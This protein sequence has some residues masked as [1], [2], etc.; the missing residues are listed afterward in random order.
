MASYIQGVTD[1]IPEIQPFKPDLNFYTKVLQ[2]KQNQYDSALKSINNLYGSLLYSPLTGQDNI[3]RRDDYFKMIEQ[4][5]KKVTS[6][7]LSLP[8]NQTIAQNIFKPLLDDK[9]LMKDYTFTKNTLNEINYG[10]SFL[11]C[12]KPEDCPGGYW[13][14]GMNYLYMQLDDFAKASPEKR[15]GMAS[16]KYVPSYNMAAEIYKFASD[17]KLIVSQA[18]PSGGYIIKKQNGKEMEPYLKDTFMAVFG[19]DPRFQAMSG[20]RAAIMRKSAIEANK[21]KFGGDE[22]KAEDDWFN[23]VITTTGTK[24][25]EIAKANDEMLKRLGNKKGAYE[26]MIRKRGVVKDAGTNDPLLKE[27]LGTVQDQ[28]VAT[29]SN[30]YYSSLKE[31]MASI[32]KNPENRDLLRSK[33]DDITAAGLLEEEIGKITHDYAMENNAIT[34]ISADPFVIEAQ[35]HSNSMKEKMFE[36]SMDFYTKILLESAKASSGKNLSYLKQT[37]GG[38]IDKPFFTSG[39][40]T[41]TGPYGT[42]GSADEFMIAQKNIAAGKQMQMG[43][44]GEGILSFTQR[45]SDIITSPNS[46]DSQKNYAKSIMKEVFGNYYNDQTNQFT[47]GKISDSDITKMGFDANKIQDFWQGSKAVVQKAPIFFGYDLLEK[48]ENLTSEELNARAMTETAWST[49]VSNSTAIREYG[50]QDAARVP[51]VKKWE[52]FFSDEG[53][54]MYYIKDMRTYITEA[55]QR[56]DSKIPI[57]TRY[58]AAREDYNKMFNTYRELYHSNEPGL[59]GRLRSLDGNTVSR[60]NADGGK[61][62]NVANYEMHYAA[63]PEA[64]GNELFSSLNPLLKSGSSSIKVV[65]GMFDPEK[66]ITTNDLTADE[67]AKMNDNPQARLALGTFLSDYFSGDYTTD[68]DMKKAPRGRISRSQIAANDY[69]KRSI[70]FYPDYEYLKKFASKK[71]GDKTDTKYAFG[72]SIDDLAKNGITVYFNAADDQS[73][74][75]RLFQQHPLTTLINTGKPIKVERPGTGG[76]TIQRVGDKVQLSGELHQTDAQGHIVNSI[77]FDPAQYAFDLG[78]TGDPTMGGN[79]EPGMLMVGAENLVNQLFRTNYYASQNVPVDRLEYDPQKL[80]QMTMSESWKRGMGEMPYKME[81]QINQQNYINEQMGKFSQI[82]K[83]LQ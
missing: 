27:Y 55:V 79:F 26:D 40:G 52:N 82:M 28:E 45:L 51:N 74:F 80:L 10:E 71:A 33:I 41:S 66:G 5:L 63:G 37:G 31:L 21:I 73:K 62:G 58:A 78:N 68:K 14:E 75:E 83:G 22:Q 67:F 59:R 44:P 4:D 23:Q 1:Y 7:D 35:R 8:Q 29:K 16:P 9:N 81:Q 48:Y 76:I 30:D 36:K 61:T 72:Y 50:K 60:F 24:L 49:L 77:T 25:Q 65:T 53:N 34:D 19:N 12:K 70:T 57:E 6:M 42:P 43:L 56:M 18:T 17:N 69:G 3:K 20:V 38:N 11:R 15:M 64:A 32:N 46:S 2:T 54:G 47:N 13:K 39:R